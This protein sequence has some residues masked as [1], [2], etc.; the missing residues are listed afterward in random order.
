[1]EGVKIVMKESENY[2]NCMTVVVPVY[3]RAH[4]IRRCLD[5]IYAQTYRPLSVVVVDNASADAT[6]REVT[7]W[8]ATHHDMDFSIRLLSEMRR[9]A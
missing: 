2:R 5:S 4:L 8:I 1:M 3:N 6:A 9:G 7:D